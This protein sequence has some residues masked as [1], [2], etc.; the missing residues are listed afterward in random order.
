MGCVDHD[1]MGAVKREMNVNSNQRRT[2]LKCTL[3]SHVHNAILL[4]A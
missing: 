4:S 3:L 1:G 2:L